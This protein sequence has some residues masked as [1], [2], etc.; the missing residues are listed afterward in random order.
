M[1][2][3][4]PEQMRMEQQE[5]NKTKKPRK[6]VRK[7]KSEYGK[8]YSGKKKKVPAILPEAL[9]ELHNEPNRH[10]LSIHCFLGGIVSKNTGHINKDAIGNDMHP[11]PSWEGEVC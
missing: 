4:S 11:P 10:L 6:K 1:H 3:C 7:K 2:E 9:I 8:K 5:W